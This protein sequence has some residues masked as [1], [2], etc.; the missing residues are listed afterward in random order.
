MTTVAG[1]GGK[2][3]VGAIGKPANIYVAMAIYAINQMTATGG[4]V[5]TLTPKA[6]VMMRANSLWNRVV[7]PVA[8]IMNNGI[9]TKLV[10]IQKPV[11]TAPGSAT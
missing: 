8:T 9:I 1:T 11:V 4:L 10:T 3:L 6:S 5:G 7:R 2:M